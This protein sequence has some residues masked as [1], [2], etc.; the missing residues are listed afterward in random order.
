M[1]ASPVKVEADRVDEPKAAVRPGAPAVGGPKAHPRMEAVV[2]SPFLPGP[3][4]EDRRRGFYVLEMLRDAGFTTRLVA[5]CAADQDHADIANLTEHVDHLHAFHR[6]GEAW[7]HGAWG[8]LTGESFAAGAAR[9]TEAVAVLASALPRAKVVVA[10]GAAGHAMVEQAMAPSRPPGFYLI[11]LNEPAAAAGHGP[12]QDE[13]S[14]IGAWAAGAE[15]RAVERAER[16]AADAAD[17]VLVASEPDIRTLGAKRRAPIWAVGNGFDPR[18]TPE[19]GYLAGLAPRI[20]YCGDVRVPHH[21]RSALWLARVVM[22]QVRK[23]VPDAALVI[24]QRGKP[25][26]G[27]ARVFESESVVPFAMK[28]AT[29]Y[30]ALVETCVAGACPQR[31]VRGCVSHALQVMAA[32][33]PLVTTSPLT[34]LLPSDTASAVA[35]ADKAKA[36]ADALRR[37]LDHREEAEQAGLKA[38][39]AAHDGATWVAQWRRVGGLLRRVADGREVHAASDSDPGARLRRLEGRTSEISRMAS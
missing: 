17:L 36:M 16:I 6:S 35:V 7:V 31:Y 12:G 9:H 21:A 24:A 19:H 10:L 37:L 23:T 11:D 27:G 29:P 25:K 39:R 15:L 22:P 4:D 5:L 30:E 26:G 1:L 18:D 2:V 38:C 3:G 32:G 34:R 13:R 33:R 8:W 28:D 20:A 14:R